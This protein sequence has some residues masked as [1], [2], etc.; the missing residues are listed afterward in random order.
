MFFIEYEIAV[1]ELRW[2]RDVFKVSAILVSFAVTEKPQ[3]TYKLCDRAVSR[4][5]KSYESAEVIKV[6]PTLIRVFSWIVVRIN[7]FA[8]RL[9]EI[10]LRSHYIAHPLP[11][12]AYYAKRSAHLLIDRLTF[13]SEMNPLW[14]LFT[15]Y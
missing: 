3:V 11:V 1:F 14:D 2:I 4:P 7:F 13:V 5:F 15:I 12:S 6:V 10:T 8:N 9:V